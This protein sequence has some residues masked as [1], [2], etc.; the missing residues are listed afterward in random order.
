MSNILGK[1][2]AF[3]P[4]PKKYDEFYPNLCI[5]NFPALRRCSAVSQLTIYPTQFQN[6]TSVKE[7]SYGNDCTIC[8]RL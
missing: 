7:G 5:L 8:A 6:L 4:L 3:L 1:I 2:L